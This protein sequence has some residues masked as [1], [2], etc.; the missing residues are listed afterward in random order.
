MPIEHLPEFKEV[1]DAERRRDFVLW[2]RKTLGHLVEEADTE[3]WRIFVPDLLGPMEDAWRE[4]QPEF[5]VLADSVA[6]LAPGQVMR[7]GLGGAQLSF[8]LE[9]VR[10]WAHR[11]IHQ[12]VHRAQPSG[13]R[14][15]EMV[16]ERHQ[17][18]AS[19]PR[20]RG[21]SRYSITG[22]E[23]RDKECDCGGR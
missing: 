14:H 16:V 23:G 18:V 1:G 8:K 20:E 17:H 19:K 10:Y 11:F 12:P 22:D 2:V 21:G 5:E 13:Q 6:D 3:Y 4:I 7:H 9:T 15:T